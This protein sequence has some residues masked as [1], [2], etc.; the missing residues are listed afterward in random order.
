MPGGLWYNFLN[1]EK[2]KVVESVKKKILKLVSAVL[3]NMLA[4]ILFYFVCILLIFY[5][6]GIFQGENLTILTIGGRILEV[7]TS[8]DTLSVFLAAIT[9]IALADLLKR[10]DAVLEEDR[11][12]EDNHHKIISIYNG[13]R[14]A[15]ENWD[16]S[17]SMDPQAQ[18]NIYNSDGQY[19][20]LVDQHTQVFHKKELKNYVKDPFSPKYDDVQDDIDTFKKGKLYLPTLNIYANVKGDTDLIFDDS[21]DLFQ[22]PDFVMEN[23]RHLLDAHKNSKRKNNSTVRL[24]DLSYE[25]GVLRLKTQRSMYFHMLITNRC[26]DYEFDEGLTMRTVYEYNKKI[27]P[28]NRSVFGNQIGINGLILSRDGYVLVEKRDNTKITWKNKFAQSI[29]LAMKVSDLK[30]KNGE[31]IGDTPQAAENIF[32]NIIQKTVRDNFGLLPEDYE[33]FTVRNNFMGIARDLLEGGK[34]NMYFYIVTKY[35]AKDLARMLRENAAITEKTKDPA[36]RAALQTDKLN[37]DYY[38]VPYDAFKVNFHYQLKINRKN[39]AYWIRRHVYPRVSR[40]AHWWEAIRHKVCSNLQP[41]ICSEC[42]E[43]LLVTMAYLEI[44]QD[45]IQAIR[46]K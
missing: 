38:L 41:Q 37:S 31:T 35:D 29:S 42:G 18:E 36:K 15:L 19:M 34:P 21:E 5:F 2:K 10:C 30:L 33:A 1:F 16:K 22:L 14:K 23:A 27:S 4:K 13:H 28:L 40:K 44:C 32:R 20:L 45:R 43:A 6:Y 39:S 24:S 25:N 26:M 12:V 3:D 7:F 46:D 11:K 17:Q 8:E 9:S